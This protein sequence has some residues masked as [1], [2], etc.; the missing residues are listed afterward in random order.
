MTVTVVRPKT[1]WKNEARW[2][3]LA[4]KWSFPLDEQREIEIVEIGNQIL[5]NSKDS[6]HYRMNF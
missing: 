2:A 1:S 3:E 4:L 6:E 5:V